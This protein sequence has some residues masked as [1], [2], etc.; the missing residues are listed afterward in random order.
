MERE[1]FENMREKEERIFG[2]EG[3]EMR[4]MSFL[5]IS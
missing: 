4:K 1:N 2:Q 5:G 3:K